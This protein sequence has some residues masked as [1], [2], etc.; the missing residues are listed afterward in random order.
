MY[1]L[2][3]GYWNLFDDWCLVFGHSLASDCSYLLPHE[4]SITDSKAEEGDGHDRN[5]IRGDDE[6]ALSNRK[7]ALESR[8]R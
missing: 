7:R 6:K 3:I 1:S 2:V 8:D 4:D 5:Q